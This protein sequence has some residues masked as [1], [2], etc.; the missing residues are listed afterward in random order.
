M[1][2]ISVPRERPIRVSCKSVPQECP[3]R[4]SQKSVLQECPTRVSDR[5]FH[6]SVCYKSVKNCLSVCIRVRGFHQISAFAHVS[7]LH[8]YE[9][10]KLETAPIVL[11][12]PP[13]QQIQDVFDLHPAAKAKVF[14]SPRRYYLV[15]KHVYSL[16][17]SLALRKTS[18]LFRSGRD[19]RHGR[20]FRHTT[21]RST[22]PDVLDIAAWCGGIA[23]VRRVRHSDPSILGPV[24]RVTSYPT[25]RF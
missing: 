20:T 16:F 17:H 15:K 24:A 19:H 10:T 6:K 3:T 11:Q 18:S 9:P 25:G 1:S 7:C 23:E 8:I 12:R 22:L 4:V 2:C 14:E 21:R 5:V 13:T